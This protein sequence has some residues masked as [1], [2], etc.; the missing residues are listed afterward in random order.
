MIIV[1]CSFR[2]LVDLS[3]SSLQEDK[4]HEFVSAMYRA[5]GVRE[6]SDITFQDFKKIFATEEY[7]QTLEK[8]TLNLDGKMLYMYIKHLRI[9]TL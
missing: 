8:A 1:Q 2:S 4:L 5:A 3:D 6:G 9:H 7:S